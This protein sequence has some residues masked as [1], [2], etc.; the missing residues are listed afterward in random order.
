MADSIVTLDQ[1]HGINQGG[2]SLSVEPDTE[3]AVYKQDEEFN[4]IIHYEDQKGD[5][6]PRQ[7]EY[8]LQWDDGTEIQKGTI[9]LDEEVMQIPVSVTSMTKSPV[10]TAWMWVLA[11]IP[12]P[13]PN[14][15]WSSGMVVG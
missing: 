6:P 12:N 7:A 4:F 5:G 2:I 15:A 9:D 10:T 8:V 14:F 11:W 13:M 3:N 1:E